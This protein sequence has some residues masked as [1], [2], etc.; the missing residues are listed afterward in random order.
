MRWRRAP[1]PR[2]RPRLPIW[3]APMSGRRMPRSCWAEAVDGLA[4]AAGGPHAEPE[5]THFLNAVT[6]ER[7]STI[8]K[9]LERYVDIAPQAEAKIPSGKGNEPKGS[10][11]EDDLQPSLGP[12]T[13]HELE[14]KGS[15]TEKSIDDEPP[16]DPTASQE[17][18]ASA[19]P[20]STLYVKRPKILSDPGLTP[21]ERAYVEKEFKIKKNAVLRAAAR[22]ELKFTSP[23]GTVRLS[24]LQQ[25]YRNAVADRFQR[26]FGVPPDLSRLNAD[27]PVDLV[28]NGI[29]TQ[30]LKLLDESI[31]KS[32]GSA[33]L[34]AAR[35][36]GLKSGDKIADIVFSQE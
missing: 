3:P 24:T 14:T 16:Q 36:A 10:A 20:G 17:K 28:V 21:E 1:R 32:V 9:G 34:Q 23:T 4:M 2:S 12:K 29:P 26:R 5:A 6:A 8:S 11:F 18:A 35:K 27:H 30:R 31:N 19:S 7:R 25:S 22:G 13:D 33:L 15:T